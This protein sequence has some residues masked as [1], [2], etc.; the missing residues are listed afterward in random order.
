MGGGGSKEAL[1]SR[2]GQVLPE[3]ERKALE[4][5]FVAIS[6]S[7]EAGSFTEAQF[8]VSH[9]AS[10]L[11]AVLCMAVCGVTGFHSSRFLVPSPT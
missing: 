9:S 2:L 8:K 4:L 5:S 3:A 11:L 7:H 1:L 6:G 10:I